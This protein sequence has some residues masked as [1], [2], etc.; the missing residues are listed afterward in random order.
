MKIDH[1][2]IWCDNLEEMRTFYIK[3]FSCSSGEK[4]FN[5]N[6]NFSSY[7]LSFPEGQ[8]RIEIMKRPD[9]TSEPEKRGYTKGIAHFCI[10]AGNKKDVDNLV[11]IIRNDGYT[12]ASEPRIS[13]DGYY[14]AAILDP[15][16]NYVE[17]SSC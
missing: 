8:T 11:A 15:E 5:P 12:I 1:L 6:K 17:I 13:G 14:E 7:F 3:Y 16:G 4:Y 9:I 10:E 2:A